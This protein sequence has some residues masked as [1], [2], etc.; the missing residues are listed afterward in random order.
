[1]PAPRTATSATRAVGPLDCLAAALARLEPAVART[2]PPARL[3][4]LATGG[5]PIRRTGAG[6]R[7]SDPLPVTVA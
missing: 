7:G 6:P 1:M 4:G 5:E 2:L 3:P